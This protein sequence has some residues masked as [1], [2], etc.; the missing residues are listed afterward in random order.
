MGFYIRKGFNFGPLR[1]NLSRSGLG[2]SFGVKG[3]RIGMGPR[4]SYVHLGRGGFY[5]RQS[6]GSLTSP[7]PLANPDVTVPTISE[8]LEEISST[9]ATAIVDASATDLLRELNRIKKRIDF[10]PII[11]VVGSALLIKILVSGF[12]LWVGVAAF[13]S[14]ASLAVGARHF[15]VTNGTAI[16]NYALG[17]EGQTE[18]TRLQTAFRTLASCQGLWHLDASG[19]TPDWKRHAG[20]TSITRRSNAQSI[21]STPPKIVCNIGVPTL[22][23]KGRS[24]YFFPD[25]MLIYDSA[26][27][28]ALP[29]LEMQVTAGVRRFVEDGSVPRD[30]KQVGSTWRYVNKRGGPDRRFNNNRELPIL[31]YGELYLSSHSGL[32]EA[33]QCS[34]PDVSSHTANDIMAFTT[35]LYSPGSSATQGVG[36]VS[37][38]S[39]G[40]GDNTLLTV[41]LWLA[42]S[43]MALMTLVPPSLSKTSPDANQQEQVRLHLQQVAAREDFAKSLAQTIA[44]AKRMNVVVS[45]KSESL[46][47]SFAGEGPKAARRDGLMP[48]NEEIFFKKFVKPHTENELCSIGF[49]AIEI[50]IN[51][52]SPT[53]EGLNCVT[54][55]SS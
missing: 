54:L 11:L 14:I 7:R 46:S 28:G 45:S 18:F 55:P 37:F 16:L 42:I 33:F 1:L 39:P 3:A 21:L 4:G 44:L 47:F 31:L 27:V 34:A 23:G 53:E 25:R 38:Q 29:Y 19:N 8:N 22:K 24:L 12:E 26:G 49:K 43:L 5:Y 40:R 51:A 10:F 30:S 35:K 41:T 20:A 50:S 9:Q 48:Y 15:D 52:A 2:A 13:V 17:Q 6:L 36:G 32:N